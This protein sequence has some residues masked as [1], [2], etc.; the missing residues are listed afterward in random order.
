[1]GTP[2]ARSA[3]HRSV[4]LALLLF[5]GAPLW[6]QQ[7]PHPDPRLQARL[8]SLVQGFHGSVGIWVHHLKSGRSAGVNADSVFPTAS[9]IKVPIMVATFDAPERGVLDFHQKPVYTDSLLSGWASP[10]S[11]WHAC[12]SIWWSTIWW[13]TSGPAPCPC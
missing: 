5:A 9:M 7:D 8:D 3:G 1:M 2:S 6:A 11:S 12:S 13:S 10:A 4:A